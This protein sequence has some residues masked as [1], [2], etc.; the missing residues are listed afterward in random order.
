MDISTKLNKLK[1]VDKML[2][3]FFFIK[4]QQH[5]K[6]SLKKSLEA[7]SRNYIHDECM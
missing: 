1:L 7:Q 5:K 6:N 3:F 4:D 2:L